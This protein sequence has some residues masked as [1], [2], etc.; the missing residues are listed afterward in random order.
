M[1][2]R[3]ATWNLRT[4]KKLR[5]GLLDTGKQKMFSTKCSNLD[6]IISCSY[7]EAKIVKNKPGYIPMEISNKMLRA[8]SDFFLLQIIKYERREGREELGVFN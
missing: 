4:Q 7:M 5:K 2:F 1:D 8:L 6:E 3:N